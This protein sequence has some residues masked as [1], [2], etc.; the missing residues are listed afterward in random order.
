MA[1]DGSAAIGSPGLAPADVREA[2]RRLIGRLPPTPLLHSEELDRRAGARLWLKAENMQRTGSFKVR[3]ALLAAERLARAGSRGVLAQS[4][5]NHAVAVAA[6]CR[7]YGLLAVLVLPEDVVAAKADLIRRTGARV[8][9]AG[10][11]LDDRLEALEELRLRLGYDVLDP[12]EDRDVVAGQGTA[13]A[14]LV[15]QA[16]EAGVRLHAVVVPV[17]GGSAVAG[18]CLAT[19]DSDVEVIAA[20]PATVPALSAAVSHGRPTTV[21]AG[22][23]IADGLRPNR[24]GALPFDVIRGRG[25]RAVTVPDSAIIEALRL[26]LEHVKVLIEPAAATALAVAAGLVERPPVAGPDIGVVLTG[27]NVDLPAILA[28]LR[29]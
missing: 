28:M 9:L 17:G 20:E 26:A 19:G 5:G 2:S 3:G 24:I 29:G 22:L 16:A 10:T 27:G 8:R 25:V 7:E 11:T 12:Y 15:A 14:E 23:T 4:T 18:A 13:T 6:A 1:G 21:A